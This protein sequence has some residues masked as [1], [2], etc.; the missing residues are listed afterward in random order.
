MSDLHHADSTQAQ[1][2]QRWAWGLGAVAIL[3]FVGFIGLTI[4]QA[5][6]HP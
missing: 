1:S 4:W 6:A 5:G 3:V 2:I